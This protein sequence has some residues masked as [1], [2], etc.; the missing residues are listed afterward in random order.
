MSLFCRLL[1][2]GC[3]AATL[4]PRASAQM[5]S[6]TNALPPESTLESWLSSED[7]RLV[8]WGAHDVLVAR[9]SNLTP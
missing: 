2:V 5:P 9:D 7:P 1:C 4:V 3:L 8:A 6:A